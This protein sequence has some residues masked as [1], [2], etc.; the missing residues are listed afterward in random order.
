MAGPNRHT[1]SRSA[2]LRHGQVGEKVGEG[3]HRKGCLAWGAGSAQQ[4]TSSEMP[5]GSAHGSRPTLADWTNPRVSPL[6]PRLF[7]RP[8]GIRLAPR[9]KEEIPLIELAPTDN[10]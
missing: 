2:T 10:E 3:Q 9:S 8:V 6:Q 7:G 4:G 1:G 5:S